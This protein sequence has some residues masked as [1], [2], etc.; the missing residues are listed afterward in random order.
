MDSGKVSELKPTDGN[1]VAGVRLDEHRFIGRM[2]AAMLLQLASDPR[3]TEDLRQR[4]GNTELETLYR[5]R[6]EV[7]RLFEGAKRRNVEQYAR[8]IVGVHGGQSG[9]T[10]P[11]ILFSEAPLPDAEQEDGTGF[12]QIPW[13]SQLVAID[14]ETQLA[15]RF[16]AANMNPSTKNEFVPVLI[17]HGKRLEWARQVFHDLNLLAVRPNAAVGIGM[18]QRDPLT[19]AARIVEEKVPFFT[20]RVNKSRRQLRKSDK[21]VVTVTSLRGA[22][23]TL[24]EGISGVKF[25]A[26]SVPVSAERIPRIE[27]AA[28][29][30]FTALTELVGSAMEDRERTVAGAPA[31]LAALGAIGHNLVA[32]TDKTLRSEELARSLTR[33]SGVNWNKGKHWEGIAGKFTPK[34]EFS[35][36]GPKETAHAIYA[37]LTDLSSAGHERVRSVAAAVA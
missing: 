18:D 28:V 6:A 1:L 11:I 32:I 36:G 7:Q 26:R 5:L 10:P 21:E 2:K 17:C 8:Y 3:R 35:I 34:G 29:E 22:C 15:A 24:A 12:I 31:V 25:G 33:L 27:L 4:L 9:M 13:G 19:H 14:G 30:W 16:E 23:I 20:D 37:A